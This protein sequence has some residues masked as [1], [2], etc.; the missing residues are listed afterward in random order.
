MSNQD[1]P[2]IKRVIS[3]GEDKY[4]QYN[5]IKKDVVNTEIKIFS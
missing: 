2:Q 4:T 3:E 5:K 1:I